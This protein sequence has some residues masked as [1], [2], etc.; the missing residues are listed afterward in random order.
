MLC[1]QRSR[2]RTIILSFE[3]RRMSFSNVKI[4]FFLHF[5]W[6]N[7][8]VGEACEARKICKVGLLSPTSSPPC[9]FIAKVTQPYFCVV[10][11]YALLCYSAISKFTFHVKHCEIK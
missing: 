8:Q 5:R 1:A 7:T 9:S 11:V 4:M 6:P 10:V 3:L 2:K